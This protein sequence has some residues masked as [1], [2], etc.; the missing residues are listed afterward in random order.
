M[1][2]QESW[3][4]RKHDNW[5]SICQIF[6]SKVF[7]FLE[8]AV[9]HEV[10]MWQLFSM[11]SWLWIHPQMRASTYL[12]WLYI[13]YLIYDRYQIIYS[14]QL[15]LNLHSPL[16]CHPKKLPSPSSSWYFNGP[17]S[18]LPI[19]RES[20]TYLW[21]IWGSHFPCNF[22]GNRFNSTAA[23]AI[24]PCPARYTVRKTHKSN[25]GCDLP[26]RLLFMFPLAEHAFIYLCIYPPWS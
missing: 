8:A 20:D 18:R 5:C 12:I 11:T 23:F 13:I 17:Q 14:I 9:D 15:Y 19:L 26:T 22:E 10:A 21:F 7:H 3:R 2:Q 25:S 4:G 6:T 16:L 1:A 24:V